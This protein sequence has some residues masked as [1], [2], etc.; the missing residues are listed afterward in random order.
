MNCA[1]FEAELQRQ[2]D[3]RTLALEKHVDEH[4]QTC[5]LCRETW[6]RNRLLVDAISSWREQLP[7][8]DLVDAVVANQLASPASGEGRTPTKPDIAVR[9]AT[10]EGL[11]RLT[12]ARRISASPRRARW[13]L[14]ALTSGLGALVAISSFSPLGQPPGGTTDKMATARAVGDVSRL[15]ADDREL[16]LLN[17]AG[18]AYKTLATSAAGVLEDFAS[19]VL[20]VRLADGVGAPNAIDGT[21][22][23]LIDGLPHPLRP[24]GQGLGDAF[25]FLWEAGQESQNSRI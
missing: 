15:S 1:E 16:A 9:P 3:C 14:A 7:D 25:D 6:N 13:A 12:T 22:D 5:D 8:A 19:I 20:P 2:L 11:P 21:G 17:R 10:S 24:I 23:R 4:L 18:A